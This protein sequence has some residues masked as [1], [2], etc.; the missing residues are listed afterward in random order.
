MD[1]SELSERQLR[2]CLGVLEGKTATQ[3]AI[4]AGYTKRH[5]GTSAGKLLK[6][7]KMAAFIEGKR[8]QMISSTEASVQ[9]VLHELA[10]VA[11]ASLGDYLSWEGTEAKLA[12]SESLTPAQRAAVS[13]V[14]SAPGMYGTRVRIKL[15]DKLR[16]LELL[17]K[18]LGM[19]E[20]AGNPDDGDFAAWLGALPPEREG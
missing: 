1:P 17:G 5:A 2:F 14:V 20:G 9:R 10:A 18:H 3:A 6:N 16:A 8:A 19:F 15:H 13:E 12:A 4:D 11:F 7:P